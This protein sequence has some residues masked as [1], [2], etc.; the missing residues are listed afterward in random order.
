M[1]SKTNNG[2]LKAANKVVVYP[3]HETVYMGVR[4]DVHLVVRRAIDDAEALT[5]AVAGVTYWVIL[6]VDERR[7]PPNLD[8]FLSRACEVR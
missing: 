5:A 4:E 2:L 8:K 6:V 7:R 3:V 1:N